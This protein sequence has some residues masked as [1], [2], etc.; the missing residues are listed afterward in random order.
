[1]NRYPVWKYAI[2]VIA[3]LLGV[4]YT[5]PNFFGEAPAVQVSSGKA[6]VKVDN[7]TLQ[8]VEEALK[9]AGLNPQ[10]LA[11]DGASI[12][13]GIHDWTIA[14]VPSGTA[15]LDQLVCRGKP[16][17]APAARP[18]AEE[19]SAVPNLRMIDSGLWRLRFIRLLQ[20]KSGRL[21]TAY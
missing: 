2:I 20:A 4:V 3:M 12:R 8:R 14:P 1:M 5:L 21:G 19:C 6:T 11:L 10:T 18:L 13:V 7:T 9:T 15:D 17:A 16:Y